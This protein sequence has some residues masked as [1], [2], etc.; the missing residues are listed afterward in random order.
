MDPNGVVV[1]E[2]SRPNRPA[3]FREM[4]HRITGQTLSVDG[5]WV[6]RL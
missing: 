2:L 3:P 6:M 1:P 4:L 5:G